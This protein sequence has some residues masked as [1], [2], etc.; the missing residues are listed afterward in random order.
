[1]GERLAREIR[2]VKYVECSALTQVNKQLTIKKLTIW[3][4]INNY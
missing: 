1:M 4:T 3:P 2:A